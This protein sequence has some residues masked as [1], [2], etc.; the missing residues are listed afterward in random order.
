MKTKNVILGM[1]LLAGPAAAQSVADYP[2]RVPAPGG[3]VILPS[4]GAERAYDEFHYAPARRAGDFLYVSGAIAG[5]MPTEG[6]DVAAFK[7]QLRRAFKQLE[8]T[9]AASGASFA[10]VVMINSFHVWDGPDFAGTKEE[11]FAAYDAVKGEFMTTPHPASTAVG[12]TGLLA[13]GGV[14]EIQLIAYVPRRT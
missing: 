2:K 13:P 9:L 11:H 14:V 10:D 5:R 1:L 6:R 8:R 4:A 12:T 3:E 7:T